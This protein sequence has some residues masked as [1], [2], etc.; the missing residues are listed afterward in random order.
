MLNRI[1]QLHKERITLRKLPKSA[2]GGLMHIYL[3]ILPSRI[4]EHHE[5]H[6][7]ICF[8]QVERPHG[9]LHLEKADVYHLIFS[10]RINIGR[11]E[12]SS[13]PY[14]IYYKIR[15][16]GLYI[17]YKANTANKTMKNYHITLCIKR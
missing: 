13:L 16:G 5:C 7:L 17:C 9:V 14:C 3:C 4:T 1:V 2:Y 12:F 11:P 10:E 8:S 15:K 6:G